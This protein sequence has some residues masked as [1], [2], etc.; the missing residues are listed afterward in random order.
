MPRSPFRSATPLLLCAGLIAGMVTTTGA[1]LPQVAD[2]SGV[3]GASA[4]HAQAISAPL[5]S[6]TARA[7]DTL[8]AARVAIADARTATTDVAMSGL[9]LATPRTDID[10]DAL[11]AYV[12]KL[13]SIDVTPTLLVPAL[14]VDASSEL[15]AVREKTAALRGQLDAAKAKKAEEEAAAKAAAE[16]AA[17]QAAAEA[18]AAQAAA[19]AAAAQEAA[20]AEAAASSSRSSAPSVDVNV[21]P[22]SAQGI[23]RSMAAGYGWGDDQF[24][25][26]LAL[27]NR[28]SGWRV[29]AANGSGAYG[30][31]QALPGSKMAS[32]G[33]DWETNP[34]TQ[35]AWGLGYISGRYGT[36]CGAWDHS[37]SAGW[38]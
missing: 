37:E 38:Y 6:I 13:S 36:P 16:A 26:L 18:A 24:S 8:D 31:P 15:Q 3:A 12:D 22:G 14:T 10:T 30:I 9:T 20:A 4:E 5:S 25:C 21:D 29:N 2:G 19:E 34:A 17:A 7:Q 23:G 32:A 28:E 27:W 1:A 11:S 35:I 33:A